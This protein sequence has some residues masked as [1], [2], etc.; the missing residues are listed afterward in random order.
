MAEPS[1]VTNLLDRKV[2][3]V[4]GKGGVGKTSV[5]AALALL[6][7]R[8]GKRPLVLTCD[9][10]PSR[11]RLLGGPP[12]GKNATN[13]GQGVHALAVDQQDALLDLLGDMLGARRL[14]EMFL[15][16][17]VVRTFTTAAPSVMEMTLLHRVDRARAA[18][19]PGGPFSPV[20]VDLP[21][22]GHALAL[23]STPRAVMRLVRMGPLFRRAQELQRMVNDSR[24]TALVAVTLAEELPVNETLELCNR[25]GGLNIPVGVVVVN[26]VPHAPLHAQ[27]ADVLGALQDGGPDPVRQWARDA[28]AGSA[29]GQR[30]WAM[31][32]RLEAAAP[33]RVAQ[34]PFATESG[35]DLAGHISRAL[36]G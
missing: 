13:V 32:A 17:R 7:A 15:A 22:S 31:I 21:A 35:K 27:D 26:A 5:S 3:L 14:V 20:I 2:I 12:E 11:G 33:G 36:D 23:L 30:A 34:V 9:G 4:T 24:N 8:R 16:N 19:E 10:R 29:R 1:E 28:L 25:A 18:D 6:A